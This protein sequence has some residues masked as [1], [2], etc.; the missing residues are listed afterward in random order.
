MSES[1]I[2]D[3]S[4]KFLHIFFSG[5]YKGSRFCHCGY[6]IDSPH[7]LGVRGRLIAVGEAKVEMTVLALCMSTH[8]KMVGHFIPSIRLKIGKLM[9]EV[10]RPKM[11]ITRDLMPAKAN[12]SSCLDLISSCGSKRT[13]SNFNWEKKKKDK[14]IIITQKIGNFNNY[15]Q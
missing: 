15:K 14:N 3:L 8:T 6:K 1:R 4:T 13:R 9:L 11:L 7:L 2:R 5:F 10:C 12:Y